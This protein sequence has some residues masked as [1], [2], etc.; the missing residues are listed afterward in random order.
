M[1]FKTTKLAP[2]PPAAVEAHLGACPACAAKLEGFRRLELAVHPYGSP[3]PVPSAPRIARRVLGVA[4]MVSALW[5]LVAL[6][7]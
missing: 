2:E 5:L 1:R 4:L 7:F 3:P 6:L